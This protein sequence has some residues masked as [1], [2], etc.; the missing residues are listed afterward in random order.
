MSDLN[1]FINYTT[2]Q[3][4]IDG[5][6]GHIIN[7]YP[8]LKSEIANFKKLFQTL[9]QMFQNNN[10]SIDDLKEKIIRIDTIN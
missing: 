3:E 5:R 9:T 8:N 1:D 7:E 6:V 2:V 10:A 4:I